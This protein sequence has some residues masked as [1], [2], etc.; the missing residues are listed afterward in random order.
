MSDKLPDDVMDFDELRG[1]IWG[2]LART[3]THKKDF[4]SKESKQLIKI[5]TSIDYY[6]E[7]FIERVNE[8]EVKNEEKERTVC[9]ESDESG[10]ID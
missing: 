8:F 10:R 1:Y 5:F 2:W 6:F 9:T 4:K 3:Y 7:W